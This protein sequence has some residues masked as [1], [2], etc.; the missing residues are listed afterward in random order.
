MHVE[1]D[2][3]LPWHHTPAIFWHAVNASVPA[4]ISYDDLEL[5]KLQF[6]VDLGAAVSVMEW[7]INNGIV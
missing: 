6:K 4:G 2:Y 5:R 7:R 1:N 3:D